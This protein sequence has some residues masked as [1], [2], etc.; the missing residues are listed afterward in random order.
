MVKS[1]EDLV[2]PS[3]ASQLNDF[4]G[5]GRYQVGFRRLG[6]RVVDP[7]TSRRYSCLWSRTV[8][9]SKTAP[10]TPCRYSLRSCA[11]VVVVVVEQT[12]A[13]TVLLRCPGGE[14]SGRSGFAFSTSHNSKGLKGLVAIRYSVGGFDAWW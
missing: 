6:R 5:V 3:I 12:A 7:R 1:L 2:L 14:I 11:A 4:E 9:G 13:R 10:D 8:R